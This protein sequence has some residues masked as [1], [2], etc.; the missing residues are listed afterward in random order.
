MF[1]FLAIQ[2]PYK[3]FKLTCWV[4]ICFKLLKKETSTTP[5]QDHIKMTQKN[6][7]LN[8]KTEKAKTLKTR[9]LRQCDQKWRFIAKLAILR[10]CWRQNFDLT[11]G[12]FLAIF[13]HI[14]ATLVAIL[15][16]LLNFC[17]IYYVSYKF[18]YFLNSF[19]FAFFFIFCLLF[20]S[21]VFS[22]FFFKLTQ[23]E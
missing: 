20:T 19:W 13:W 1:I 14:S 12:D 4:E 6:Q 11:T 3:I 22:T 21:S 15:D 17:K 16:F 10:P 2:M 7:S 5:F 23:V 9:D 8:V 18:W